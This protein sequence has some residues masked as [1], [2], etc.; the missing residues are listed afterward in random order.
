M[1]LHNVLSVLTAPKQLKP[2]SCAQQHSASTPQHHGGTCVVKAY[3]GCRTADWTSSASSLSQ[4][5]SAAAPT[6]HEQ[7]V[8]AATRRLQD[9]HKRRDTTAKS[10]RNLVLLPDGGAKV[11]SK[12]SAALSSLL[13][14][15]DAAVEV[16]C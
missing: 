2:A 15:H 5:F 1:T 3:L 8:S 6:E 9:L 7:K 14:L 11:G 13:L 16:A 4:S 10:L 12:V